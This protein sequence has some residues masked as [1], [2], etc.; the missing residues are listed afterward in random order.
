MNPPTNFSELVFI[1]VD[2]IQAALPVIFG[3][4]FLV[5]LWGLVKFIFRLEGDEK[6]VA[7]G[8]NLMKWGLLALFVMVSIWGILRF[9]YNDLGLSPSF[10]FPFLPQ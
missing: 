10:G 1:F 7:D 6:A 9:F 8:K 2:L 5:F 4:A 3:L